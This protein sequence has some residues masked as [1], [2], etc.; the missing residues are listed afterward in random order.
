MNI[1]LGTYL[2]GGAGNNN[3][4]NIAWNEA[5]WWCSPKDPHNGKVAALVSLGCGVKQRSHLFG[6]QKSVFYI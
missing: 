6:N 3:P 1:G 4:S 5:K 2:D